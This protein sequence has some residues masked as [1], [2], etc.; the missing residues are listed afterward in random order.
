MK[1]KLLGSKIKSKLSKLGSVSHHN[2]PSSDPIPEAS[3]PLQTPI[4]TASLKERLWN[5]AYDELKS[6][7]LEI[8]EAYEK[9]LSAQL[10]E[11][12]LTSTAVADN[13]IKPTSQGRWRQMERLVEAGLQKTSKDAATKQKISDM[14]YI[15]SPLKEVVGKALQAA[16]QAA[17]AWVGVSFA[18]EMLANPV[19]EPGINR[20]GIE[21]VVSRMNWYWNLVDLLLKPKNASP[22]L[23][24]L[25][26]L[27][28]GHIVELYKNLLIYQMKSICI[29]H[30]SRLAILFR[31]LI[32]LD[33]WAGKIDD[34]Q[35]VEAAVRNDLEQYNT[36]QILQHLQ[37]IEDNAKEQLK[38]LR[39]IQSALHH[40][41]KQNNE[42]QQSREFKKCL[43]DLRVTDPRDDKKRIQDIKGGLL[44]DSYV[45]VLE[46][47]SFCQWR[48][49]QNQRLLWVKGD[50]GKGKTML[51]CGIID[52]LEATY[53]EGRMLSYFFCQATD[54]RLNTATAVLRGLIFMLLDQEPSLISYTKSKYDKSGK[55]LFQDANAWQ[56]MSEIFTN[57]LCDSKL[58][59]VF[60]LVDALDECSAGL[61]QLLHLI[62]ET[63]K[64]TS[65]KWLVS[66]RNW[67][68]IEEQ[69]RT[70]AQR[71][72]LE[73]HAESVSAAVDIYIKQ[74]VKELAENKGYDLKTRNRVL[75]YLSNHAGDTFLWVAL[76]FQQLKAVPVLEVQRIVATFP[77][78]LD[79]L[80][81]RMMQQICDSIVHEKCMQLLAVTVVLY[82]PLSLLEYGSVCD[83]RSETESDNSDWDNSDSENNGRSVGKPDVSKLVHELVLCCGS[84]LT[85]RE[86]IVY[87][88]HQSAKDFLLNK[89]YFAFDHILP[90]GIAHQHYVIFSRSMEALSGTLRRDIYELRAPGS[91]AED[92]SPPTPDP[93]DPLKYFCTY[94][95][96]HLDAAFPATSPNYT[97]EKIYET[98]H[99]FIKHKYLYWLEALSI[100]R[101][102][103]QAVVAMRKLEVLVANIEA[104][105]LI[106]VVRDARR[107][108]LSHGY[109]I[110][111]C[112]LQVYIAALLF[113]PTDSIIRQFFE[114]EAPAWIK[115]ITEEEASWDACLQ[116]L[117]GHGD[118]VVSVAC[119]SD[120][121]HFGSGS[122]DM[123]VKVWDA[124]TGQCIQT[125]EGHTDS[126]NVVTFSGKGTHQLASASSD[127]TVKIWDYR[128]GY[129]LRT[130][131]GHNHFVNSV[132][133]SAGGD[134]IASASSDNTVKIWESSTARCV[135]TLEGHTGSV[136]AVA[137]S[138]HNTQLASASSDETVKIW[139]AATG[140]CLQ[141]L[142][143]HT[144]FVNA[145]AFLGNGTHQLATASSDKT[146][147]IWDYR[148]GNCLQTFEGHGRFVNS[149]VFSA[150]GDR[151]V[152]ASSDNTMKIWESSTGQCLQTLRGHNQVIHAVA[153]SGDGTR[154]ASA[155]S[156]MTVKIWDSALVG[157]RRTLEAHSDIIFTVAFSADGTHIASASSDKTLKVWDASNGKCLLT[158]EGHG[159]AV[160]AV[161]FSRDGNRL[162]SASFDKTIKV[163]DRYTGQCLRTLEGHSDFIFSVAF[164]GDGIRIASASADRTVKIWDNNTGQCLRTLEG[165]SQLVSSVAF[166]GDGTQLA[167]ASFDKT[168]KVWDC[169]TGQ[170]LRTF[171]GH[172]NIIYAVAFSSDGARIA[173]ASYNRPIRIWDGASM[174]TLPA[175][176]NQQS[177]ASSDN[178][179]KI[180]DNVTG[181][182]IRTFTKTRLLHNI[183][184][185]EDGLQ[186][187]TEMGLIDLQGKLTSNSTFITSHAPEKPL[188][189]GYSISSN[190]VW[191]K[192]DSV[193]LLW[194]PPEYRSF[195]S[196]IKG[197]AVVIGCGTGRVVIFRF[198]END[199]ERISR[200]EVEGQS[201]LSAI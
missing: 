51:L 54:D 36:Q 119:S 49:D 84:L 196:A 66:S 136:N 34:I 76:V 162:A 46:N 85:I 125:L 151:I 27:L 174:V 195:V 150:S 47:L 133:F 98:V 148:T 142:E 155:S 43:A 75:R 80:Y 55:A 100:L 115:V 145:V 127:K 122:V 82:R 13:Q 179:I 158:L 20:D 118:R 35:T 33:D 9:L 68:Q 164:S 15:I 53:P 166:S 197:P 175:D 167:S 99:T 123:T 184:F 121:R 187:D 147:K 111:T 78:G 106:E 91:L 11:D 132:A 198:M 1:I 97:H 38:E 29:Y 6:S 169:T 88:V 19:V 199:S 138:G 183:H 114:D 77:P 182:H 194:L 92:I 190:D 157:Y 5:Q 131:E 140:R 40:Q 129:C 186:L 120:G 69:L 134:R 154:L 22:D 128:T 126:V 87:F 117:E 141:T 156:D 83:L 191:I 14:I 109:M 168:V 108:V 42:M 176:S 105:K 102:I 160:C 48:N 172:L 152:S 181:H 165:H 81:Q 16:P 116:T 10:S 12:H 104:P 90:S 74:K 7:E 52:E 44:T 177:L 96:D 137:F 26:A 45:W 94:W 30:R 21:Y 161:V 200:S 144:D 180:W 8:V 143:G 72:S 63:S 170:C 2:S 79:A 163:W 18:L 60:L 185:S 73:L 139:D 188:F 31:D 71:L 193:H 159:S 149:V 112:P 101:G 86:G 56:A 135:Q 67:L 110:E 89:T 93:L 178:T 24:G 3:T 171:R 23:E 65:A 4:S 37:S 153:F 113:S 201:G 32:R 28:K 62:T 189:Q 173:S 25:R 64:S 17:I 61:E 146:I 39:S 58:Q 107:F 192:R 95:V 41:T 59:G 50:P 130:L 57:M 70:A 124:A 103:S